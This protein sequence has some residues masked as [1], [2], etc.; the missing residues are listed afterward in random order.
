MNFFWKPNGGHSG[1]RNHFLKR[2]EN[3]I[4]GGSDVKPLNSEQSM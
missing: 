2:L 4:S 3:Q 1:L